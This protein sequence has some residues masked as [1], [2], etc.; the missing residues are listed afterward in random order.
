ML[1]QMKFNLG[2]YGLRAPTFQAPLFQASMEHALQCAWEIHHLPH[3]VHITSAA[4]QGDL[5]FSASAAEKD[6]SVRSHT[7]KK[8]HI[9]VGL[10]TELTANKAF[11]ISLNYNNYGINSNDNDNN[12]VYTAS[13][14]LQSQS[15]VDILKRYVH[16]LCG[17]DAVCLDTYDQLQHHLT[18]H[19]QST[20]SNISVDSHM[21]LTEA[22][23]SLIHRIVAA[24]PL[25]SFADSI[26][27]V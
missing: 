16:S 24:F 23:Y 14:P 3:T 8:Y 18:N 13:S 5:S 7:T 6:R 9:K 15:S 25:S 1:P 17:R 4:M 26:R 10:P 12:S 2:K 27:Y 19:T 22:Q 20:S 11:N 21:K